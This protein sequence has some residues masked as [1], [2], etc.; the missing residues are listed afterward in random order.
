MSSERTSRDLLVEAVVI[1]LSILLAFAIDAAWDRHQRAQE[2]R[3]LLLRFSEELDFFEETLIPEAAAALEKT[4]AATDRV[5]LAIHT[6]Q[7]LT[8][9]SLDVALSLITQ[10]YQF[11][12]ASPVF[13]VLTSDGGL[14]RVKDPAVSEAL[15]D[16]SAYLALVERFEG[17]DDRFVQEQ[18]IP[19]L[20]RNSDRYRASVLTVRGFSGL[21]GSVFPQ[22]PEILSSR[23]F[24]NLLA[25][26]RRR[27][28]TVGRFREA[29]T[30]SATKARVAVDAYLNR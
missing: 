3:E 7:D 13:R 27:L 10:G 5:I 14:V 12:A 6:E 21:P 28:G 18:L 22:T 30:I 23:E 29:F 17:L 9:D 1:V 19:F 26:R 20:N 16:M 24:S 8:S 25:E 11:A 2:E 4:L 15:A